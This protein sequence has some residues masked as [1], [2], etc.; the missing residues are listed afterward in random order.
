[1][2]RTLHAQRIVVAAA[3]VTVISSASS[4]VSRRFGGGPFLLPAG[5]RARLLEAQGEGWVGPARATWDPEHLRIARAAMGAFVSAH[6]S[7]ELAA[8]LFP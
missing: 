2:A 1:M 6:L 5:V 8:R 3:P 4:V 7:E